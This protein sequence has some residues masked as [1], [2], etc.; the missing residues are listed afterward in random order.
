MTD[1]ITAWSFSR[2]AAYESCPAKAKYKF[3]DKL[4]EPSSEALERGTALHKLCEDYLRG[5][6]KAVPAE[7]KLIADQL[8][9]LRRAKALPE[10]E[11]AF[12]RE[13]NPVSWFDR[14]A[15]VRVKA[16]AV[17][18]PIID[19]ELPLVKVDDFKSGGKLDAATNTVVSKEEYPLQLEL[20]GLAGLITY[21]VAALAKTSL[22]FID[23]GRV[24]ESEESFT[25]KDVPRLK[26]VWEV[27]TKKM[28]AD[29]KFKPK[30][31]N[32]CRWCH[33]RKANGGPCAY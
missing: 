19:V 5:I 24:V 17:V 12:D 2:W 27:R 32:A 26:K 29:T 11:F 9:C 18:P 8:K 3:I 28:L 31:G 16:D 33:F 15:W 6:K 30:P 4:P 25:P 1:K 14:R 23:H 10:A 7:L 20:Y 22:V 13:W 21:P